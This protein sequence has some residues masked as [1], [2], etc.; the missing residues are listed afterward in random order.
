M[1]KK[2]RKKRPKPKYKYKCGDRVDIEWYDQRW[3]ATIIKRG[4]DR[5]DWSPKYWITDWADGEIEMH[6]NEIRGFNTLYYMKN[7]RYA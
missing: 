3:E 7:K 6:E 1:G 4:I 5:R 2:K